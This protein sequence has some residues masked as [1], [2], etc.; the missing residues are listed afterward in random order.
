MRTIVVAYIVSGLIFLFIF[1][2]FCILFKSKLKRKN[3]AREDL[4]RKSQRRRKRQKS[5]HRGTSVHHRYPHQ[6]GSRLAGETN[7]TRTP[8]LRQP[9]R[10]SKPKQTILDK[11]R[12]SG[13][14]TMITRLSEDESLH[15]PMYDNHHQVIH[16]HLPKLSPT[17]EEQPYSLAI[18]GTNVVMTPEQNIEGNV[19]IFYG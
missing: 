13:A 12:L 14:V 10:Q 9:F 17:L 4:R 5:G 7:T 18:N 3:H 15:L 8:R 11:H 19:K 1:S 16:D 6:S 2:F